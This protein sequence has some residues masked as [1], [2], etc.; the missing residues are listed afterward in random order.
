[1][2]LILRILSPFPVRMN[3]IEQ[4]CDVIIIH[5]SP[6]LIQIQIISSQGLLKRQFAQEKD[7][8]VGNPVSLQ[9]ALESLGPRC[10]DILLKVWV[11]GLQCQRRIIV[12]QIFQLGQHP[13]SRF[14]AEISYH[15]L[16]LF[17]CAWGEFDRFRGFREYFGCDFRGR[18]D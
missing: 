18:V 12:I 8:W 1:M 2:N 16:K 9:S 7:W 3:F 17:L 13:L 5:N 15:F 10:I 11:V 4:L 6:S 14:D